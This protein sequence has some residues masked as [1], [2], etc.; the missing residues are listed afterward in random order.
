MRWLLVLLLL[1]P[2]R[3]EPTV[4]LVPL[5]DRPCNLLF[6]HQLARVAGARIKSPPRSMLGQWLRPGDPGLVAAW[7]EKQQAD[8]TLISADMLCYGGL[9]GARQASTSLTQARER[10]EVLRRLKGEITVLGILPR[11]SLRTSDEEAPYER[12]LAAWAHQPDAPMP[13][14][15]PPLIVAEYLSVRARNLQTLGAMLDYLEEGSIDRL[16]VGQDDSAATGRHRQESE[17]LL[18][19]VSRRHLED[20][21]LFLTGADELSMD[22][23]SGWLADRANVHPRV[24][25]IYS[26]PSAAERVPPLETF[27]LGSMLETHVALAGG[28]VVAENPEV[29]LMVRAPDETT[30]LEPFLREVE[31]L[32]EQGRRVAVADL[33]LVNR[34]EP[35]LAQGLILDIPLTRL[36]AL[37]GWNTAANALGTAAAQLVCHRLAAR[38]HGWSRRQALESEKTHQAFLLAR[39]VDDYGYQ[40]I[41]RPASLNLPLDPD[42]LL[43]LYGPIGLEIRESLVDWGRQLFASRFRNR[44][45]ALESI[46]RQARIDRLSLEVVLPWQRVFEVEVRADLTLHMLPSAHE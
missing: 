33:T 14:D 29:V 32:L 7:L 13:P 39:L 42:P 43:N 2:V 19:E 16:I 22:L 28:R 31:R 36:E 27:P 20:R 37:A 25:V 40:A 45:V 6:V 35:A 44:V 46:G 10:L 8:F 41:V 38:H 18:R 17:W 23:V 26:D 15:V 11:L 24:Q 34:M 3:A 12:R 1:L 30:S 4:T 21:F 5:D 9:V